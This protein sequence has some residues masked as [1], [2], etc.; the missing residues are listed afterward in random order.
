MQTEI[1]G[2]HVSTVH[3]HPQALFLKIGHEDDHRWSKHAA[4]V[5]WYDIFFN[6][7]WV[8]TRWQ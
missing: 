1:Q 7:N 3:G 2:L 5:F 6:C 8:V 4:P